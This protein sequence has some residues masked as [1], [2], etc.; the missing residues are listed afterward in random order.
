MQMT[1]R[2]SEG[3][4]SWTRTTEAGLVWWRLKWHEKRYPFN[5]HQGLLFDL[6]PAKTPNSKRWGGRRERMEWAVKCLVE[7]YELRTGDYLYDVGFD[8]ARKVIRVASRAVI[9][10]YE[11]AVDMGLAI[12]TAGEVDWRPTEAIPEDFYA[13]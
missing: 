7:G 10:L 3:G 11:V 2:V 9:D 6:P 5:D 4:C 12:T 13:A 1:R 8:R